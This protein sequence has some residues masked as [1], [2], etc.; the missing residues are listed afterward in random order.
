MRTAWALAVATILGQISWV[1]VPDGART[2]VTIA[3]V[4]TFALASATHAWATRGARWTLAYLAIAIGLGW[5][6]E[7]VGT[8]TGLPFGDYAYADALG[9]QLLGVPLVIPLAWSMMAYPCLLAAQR[10]ARTWWATALVGGFLFA[11]WDLFLD[12]QM[13]GEG[14]WVWHVATPALPGID[15]IPVQNFLGWL[16]VALVLMLLLDRLPRI[17]ADD[18]VPTVLLSWVYLSNVLSAAVFFGRPA[19]AAW[20]GVCMGLVV[21]P[22]WLSLRRSAT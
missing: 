9:P 3:T 8:A 14:Y 7:A 10:L 22:W 16:F 19:V 20:G 6:A 18:T 5:S 11:S 21:V 1:L 2:A 15:A 12:P 4:I 17:A 13:V